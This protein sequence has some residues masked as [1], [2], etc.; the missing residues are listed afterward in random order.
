MTGCAADKGQHEIGA[1]SDPELPSALTAQFRELHF[2]DQDLSLT[3]FIRRAPLA[4]FGPSD[5]RP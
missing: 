3:G 5:A 1:A 2:R 4:G